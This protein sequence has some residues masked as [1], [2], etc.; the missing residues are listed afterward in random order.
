MWK[1]DQPENGATIISKSILKSELPILL[2]VHDA[3]D[4]GWLF[5]D[6]QPFDPEGIAIVALREAVEFDTSVE[7]E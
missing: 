3:D 4:D 2:V 1:F 7:H 6:G 5:L